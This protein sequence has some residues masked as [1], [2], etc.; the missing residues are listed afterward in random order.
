MKPKATGCGLIS[1]VLTSIVLLCVSS[2]II[3]IIL[4]RSEGS[5][6]LIGVQDTGDINFGL[7]AACTAEDT[8]NR[9]T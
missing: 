3:V 1:I 8:E 6:G 4:P 9:G 2:I 7:I 5:R